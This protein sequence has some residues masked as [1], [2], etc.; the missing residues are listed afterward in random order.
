MRECPACNNDKSILIHL[1]ESFHIVRCNL[2]GL[3]YLANPPLDD[4]I[5]EEYHEGSEP[6]PN[7]YRK[8][9]QNH[10]L[11]ELWYIN[12]QRLKKLKRIK[13]NGSLLDI[14][15]GRGY[16]LKSAAE[17]GYSVHGIDIAS[18]PIKYAQ[19]M[20]QLSADT[21]SLQDLIASGQRYEIITLFHV[22]E[23]FSD[24]YASLRYVHDLL[25]ENGL[26]MI[27]VPNYHSLKFVIS[28]NKW[29]G[30]NHPL[31]HRTF[32]TNRTLQQSLQKTGFSQMKRITLSYHLH[33]RS[34]LYEGF[35]QG[36]NIFGFDAF[37]FFI[38]WK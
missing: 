15:C 17:S 6:D 28:K 30:G 13:S 29:S 27:E 33:D 12:S 8:D 5:Y 25:T 11:C 16:F 21:R 24:P 26:C 3:V 36:L 20:Y 38:A 19:R 10:P 1:V 9:S 31:Y 34:I 23:H 14:G 22:L 37:L 35:K 4:T 32:F 7:D 18:R 2:C